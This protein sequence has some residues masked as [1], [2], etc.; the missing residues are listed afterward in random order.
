MVAARLSA[1]AGRSVPV[2]GQVLARTER[3]PGAIWRC[4][5]TGSRR[6][7]AAVE[8]IQHGVA[9]VPHQHQGTTG[10]ATGAASMTICRAQ[11]V[12]FLCRRP[13]RW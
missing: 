11:S 9:I 8:Q 13:C 1:T 2:D 3:R 4:G 7:L 12:I 5:V 6:G 10:A